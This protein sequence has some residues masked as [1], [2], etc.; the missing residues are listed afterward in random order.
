M[1]AFKGP[2]NKVMSSGVGNSA[3]VCG[4]PTSGHAH[5]ST[6]WCYT[7]NLATKYTEKARHVII[8]PG[9]AMTKQ[10]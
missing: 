9:E 10:S 1:L 7:M 8:G 5:I 4:T 2:S 6:R 3:I